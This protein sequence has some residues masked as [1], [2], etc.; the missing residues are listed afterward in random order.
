MNA[1]QTCALRQPTEESAPHFDPANP[2]HWECAVEC[3]CWRCNDDGQDV[4]ACLPCIC[5]DYT[6]DQK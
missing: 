4:F 5:P 6:E 1:C 3:V 2:E